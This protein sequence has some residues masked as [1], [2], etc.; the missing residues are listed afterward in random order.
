MADTGLIVADTSVWIEW[1][2][3]GRQADS[4]AE[5]LADPAG[6]LLVPSICIYEVS[7]WYLT[8]KR[9]KDAQLAASEMEQ[10]AVIDLSGQLAR[11]AALLSAQH[12]LAMADAVILA[13]A[14][15]HDATLW[16]QD[17]DFSGLAGVRLFERL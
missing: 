9:E 13:T 10:L 5:I 12:C 4:Y 14:R 17:A 2:T 15:T 6:R 7:R 8:R 3:D 16:T 1:L 11:E